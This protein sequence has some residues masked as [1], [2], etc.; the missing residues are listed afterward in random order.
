MNLL[1]QNANINYTKQCI[2]L[3][4]AI[5]LNL[6]TVIHQQPKNKKPCGL[7]DY[8]IEQSFVAHGSFK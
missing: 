8:T 2:L 1:K 6:C 4:C 7:Q 5:L 3:V